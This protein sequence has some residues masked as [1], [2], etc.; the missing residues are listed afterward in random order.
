MKDF[1]IANG[2]KQWKVD[3]EHLSNGGW[4]TTEMYQKRLDTLDKFSDAPLCFCNDKLLINVDYC[5]YHI[6]NVTSSSYSISIVHSDSNDLWCDLKIYSV[7]E[8]DMKEQL[9][10]LEERLVS[11]WKVFYGDN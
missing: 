11:M 4:I 7:S 9:V 1:L 2:Y 5:K 8:Q 3:T 10:E 6:N